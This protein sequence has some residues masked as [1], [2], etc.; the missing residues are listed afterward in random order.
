MGFRG[1]HS[2]GLDRG[3]ETFGTRLTVFDESGFCREFEIDFLRIVGIETAVAH[4]IFLG[5][6]GRE[7]RGCRSHPLNFSLEVSCLN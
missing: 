4:G 6:F 2:Q 5:M 7:I 1:C 3:G